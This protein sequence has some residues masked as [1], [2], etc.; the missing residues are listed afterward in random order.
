LIGQINSL[1]RLIRDEIEL[2]LRSMGC[3]ES[4]LHMVDSRVSMAL[5]T[6]IKREIIESG[7]CKSDSGTVEDDEEIVKAFEIEIRTFLNETLEKFSNEFIVEIEIS[8]TQH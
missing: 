2:F 6:V 7:D 4:L 1:Y 3:D 8:S 5:P